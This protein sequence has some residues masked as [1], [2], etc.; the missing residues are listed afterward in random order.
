MTYWRQNSSSQ[1]PELLKRIIIYGVL[2]LFLGTAQS[3]FFPLLDICPATPDLILAL[4]LCITLLDG[5]SSALV[6][7]VAGGFFLDAIS[8]SGAAILPA[9]YFCFVIFISFFVQ[10]VLKSFLSYL[11]LLLPTLLFRA[12]VTIARELI[13]LGG[14]P[15]SSFI[16]QILLP[17]AVCTLLFAIPLY[18]LLKLCTMP[19]QTH[20]KF[21]F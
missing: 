3:A 14:L 8:S 15:S 19:L 12:A 1:R 13:A 9:V 2:V 20:G 7:A 10:K 16:L 11:F 6:C 5:S 18:F 17:E 21:S 4:L